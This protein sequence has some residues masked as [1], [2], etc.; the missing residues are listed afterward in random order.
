MA[1]AVSRSLEVTGTLDRPDATEATF[2]EVDIG[3]LSGN[4][5]VVESAGRD[6]NRMRIEVTEG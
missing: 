6:G 3:P 1:W 4:R 5:T 2:V